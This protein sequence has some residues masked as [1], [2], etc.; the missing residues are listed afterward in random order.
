LFFTARR[1]IPQLPPLSV[2]DGSKKVCSC[3]TISVPIRIEL[4]VRYVAVTNRLISK[5]GVFHD[6]SNSGGFLG[7]FRKSH[8]SLLFVSIR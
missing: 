3:L 7:A 1:L 8:T 6:T 5:V 4:S 2:K